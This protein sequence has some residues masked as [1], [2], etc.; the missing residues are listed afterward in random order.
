MD[1]KTCCWCQGEVAKCCLTS[2]FKW[3]LVFPTWHGPLT[4]TVMVFGLVSL[5]GKKM[6]PVFIDSGIRSTT[7]SW[8]PMPNLGWLPTMV[9]RPKF[10]SSRT[11][12][13]LTHPRRPKSGWKRLSRISGAR[14]CGPPQLPQPEPHGLLQLLSY[15]NGWTKFSQ[16]WNCTIWSQ[17]V[18][19]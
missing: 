7:A 12:L 19:C 9:Q 2:V 16:M 5:D 14:I 4:T 10:S 11:E 15:S 13:R 17:L 6:P 3:E 8:R 18:C 1:D